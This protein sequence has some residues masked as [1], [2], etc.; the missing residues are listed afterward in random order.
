MANTNSTQLVSASQ[1]YWNI[2]NAAQTGLSGGASFS[3]TGWFYLNSKPPNNGNQFFVYVKSNNVGAN[4]SYWLDVEQD[5]G[6]TH[7]VATLYNIGG[8]PTFVQATSSV[9]LSINTWYHFAFVFTAGTSVA[10]Y[11]NAANVATTATTFTA[12]NNGTS[13]FGIGGNS[14]NNASGFAF[15]GL[16]DDVM[17]WSAVLNSTQV[18]A[19]FTTPCSPSTTNLVSRW[20][21]D[22]NGLDSQGSNNLTNQ[23]SATFSTNVAY[24]CGGVSVIPFLSLM[25]VGV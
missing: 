21:F 9:A 18:T 7:A 4:Q 15:D 14:S 6:L 12:A 23:N 11:I 25:G 19:L 10:L 22:G 8:A 20:T 3:V 5:A 2:T 1:Q 16:I 24:T 17:F 13:D